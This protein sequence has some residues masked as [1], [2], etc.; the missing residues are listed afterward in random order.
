MHSLK[1]VKFNW[2]QLQEL[3]VFNSR[4]LSVSVDKGQGYSRSSYKRRVVL[5]VFNY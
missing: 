1:K 2:S 3:L 5:F 4:F